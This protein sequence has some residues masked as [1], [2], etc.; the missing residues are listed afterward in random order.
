MKDQTLFDPGK[1]EPSEFEATSLA[2]LML[3]LQREEIVGLCRQL[4]TKP[5]VETYALFGKGVNFWQLSQES[6]TLLIKKLR[7]AVTLK[8]W[9]MAYEAHNAADHDKAGCLVCSRQGDEQS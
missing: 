5:I 4:K 7:E 8:A 3:P 2:T 6:A 1:K 9:Q